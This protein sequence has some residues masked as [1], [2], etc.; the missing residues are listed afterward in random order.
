MKMAWVVQVQGKRLDPLNPKAS[1]SYHQYPT[2]YH[3]NRFSTSSD[4]PTRSTAFSAEE[5]PQQRK[6]SVLR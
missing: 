5:N 2:Q 4:N 1:C 6:W 3:S